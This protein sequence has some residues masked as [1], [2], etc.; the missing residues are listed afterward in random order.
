M[1]RPCPMERA[2]V[3]GPCRRRGLLLP[4]TGCAPSR[5]LTLRAC[6]IGTGEVSRA[7]SQGL[8]AGSHSLVSWL[9]P[10]VSHRGTSVWDRVAQGT[11]PVVSQAVV[12][13]LTY[14]PEPLSWSL[15]PALCAPTVSYLP[16]GCEG[17]QRG[18]GGM[19]GD[20]GLLENS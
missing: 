19:R 17:H 9:I 16:G 8:A 20:Q 15:R 7:L 1:R 14:V 11:P 3:L 10:H 12:H 18:G 5:G 13:A 4:S 6:R 2:L